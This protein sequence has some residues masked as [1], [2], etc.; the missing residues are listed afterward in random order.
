V[1]GAA[2]V[3]LT[4]GVSVAA[5]LPFGTELM[6][7]GHRYVVQ[8]RTADWIADRYDGK[9]IDMYFDSHEAALEWGKRQVEVYEIN[10]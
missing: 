2:G 7:D 9:I 10:D 4:P 5:P 1:I 3:E 8:D 6:I